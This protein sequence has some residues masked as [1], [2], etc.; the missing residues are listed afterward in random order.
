MKADL[1]VPSPR[2]VEQLTTTSHTLF[3]GLSPGRSITPIPFPVSTNLGSSRHLTSSVLTSPSSLISAWGTKH[4]CWQLFLPCLPDHVNIQLSLSVV[5]P[6]QLL[7]CLPFVGGGGGTYVSLDLVPSLSLTSFQAFLTGY[8]W[9][10]PLPQCVGCNCTPN[11]LTKS[12]LC[13]CATL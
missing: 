4:P 2:M 12:L 10:H 1:V 8:L 3:C 9:L 13:H 11:V 5:F 7:N 6:A